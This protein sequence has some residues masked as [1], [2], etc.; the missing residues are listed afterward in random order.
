[1]FIVIKGMYAEWV[2][3]QRLKAESEEPDV[4]KTILDNA[5]AK[6]D[7]A[8]VMM[9]KTH[10]LNHLPPK[11]YDIFSQLRAKFKGSSLRMAEKLA[12]DVSGHLTNDGLGQLIH[13]GFDPIVSSEEYT[14]KYAKELIESILGG[15]RDQTYEEF[16]SKGKGVFVRFVGETINEIV[17]GFKEGEADCFKWIQANVEKYHKANTPENLQML[18]KVKTT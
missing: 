11:V 2:E 9:G 7:M 13:E 10:E 3:A 15:N 5:L 17:D 14:T 4:L 12:D 16:I 18:V 8:K 1:M 6:E